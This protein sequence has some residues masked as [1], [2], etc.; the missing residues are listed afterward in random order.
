MQYEIKMYLVFNFKHRFMNMKNISYCLLAGLIL[1]PALAR[2]MN[3]QIMVSSLR[4]SKGRTG[5]S[6]GS[7]S[8]N[9][10]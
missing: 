4:F 2:S 8:G 5:Y 7:F 6:P 1:G 9:G 3:R 10:R